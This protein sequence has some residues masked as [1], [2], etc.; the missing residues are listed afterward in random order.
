MSPRA[1]PIACLF[2]LGAFMPRGAIAA[3]D[4]ETRFTKQVHPFIETYC[5]SCHGGEKPKADLDLSP[6][7]TMDRVIRDYAYWDLVLEKLESGE[8]PNEKA[9]KFP[10]DQAR[11]EIVDWIQAMRKGEAQKNA[12]DPGPVL[13]R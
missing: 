5:V 10:T 11:H 13:A 2:L 1:H 4:L 7:S 9:E 6:Y 8:M 3:V 12:G